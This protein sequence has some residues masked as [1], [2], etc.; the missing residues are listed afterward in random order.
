MASFF[1]FKDKKLRLAFFNKI[2]ERSNMNWKQLMG[3][4]KIPK[5]SLD[6]YKMG[7]YMPQSIFDKLFNY[8]DDES[9]E[10]FRSGLMIKD[11]KDWLV[12]GGKNAYKH[13][14]IKFNEGRIKGI[15]SIRKKIYVEQNYNFKDF[16]LSREICQFIGAFIGDGF[17]NCYKNKLYQIEFAGDSRY[18]LEYYQLVIIPAIKK[19]IPE[20]NPHIYYVK[21]KNSLRVVFYS[22]KLFYFL[23]NEFGFKPGVKTYDVLIPKRVMESNDDFIHSAIRGIFD[24]D[25]T[26]FLDRRKS[27]KKPYPRISLQTAS[28]PLYNQ[29]K[30]YLLKFFSLNAGKNRNRNIY[31]I[32]IYG[33]D[34][35]RRWMSEIG[36]SN[37]RHL[38]KIATIA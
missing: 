4:L 17:F 20:L 34:S 19:V 7:V 8:L 13:N 5:S 9:K 15:N 33:F 26:F 27:Y 31:Y 10:N 22:K 30:N 36:F 29:L 35:L 25:G 37:N 12:L 1:K 18:D 16:H 2:R 32:E 21:N 28:E 11:S 6:S 3:L 14:I 23:K 24:T 38:K